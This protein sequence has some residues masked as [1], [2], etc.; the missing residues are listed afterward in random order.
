VD[1]AEDSGTFFEW[2]KVSAASGLSSGF[3][4][5]GMAAF[6]MK[7]LDFVH[8]SQ[9]WPHGGD[10]LRRL[11]GFIVAEVPRAFLELALKLKGTTHSQA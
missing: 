10:F 2:V 4:A 1:A 6:G 8:V 7:G 3:A 5:F 11:E 9:G